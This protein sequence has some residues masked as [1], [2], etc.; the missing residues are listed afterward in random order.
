[1]RRR[2]HPTLRRGRVLAAAAALGGV[3]ALVAMLSLP[4]S[5]AAQ[6]T[7]ASPD[8]PAVHSAAVRALPGKRLPIRGRSVAIV[9]VARGVEATL[10][11]LHAEVTEREIRIDLSADVLFDFDKADLKP[12]ADADLGKVA[13]VARAN[14][15]TP[16]QVA[17]HTD[18]KG[19]DAYNQRLSERRAQSVKAWLVERGNVESAR[20]ETRGYGA[21]RPVAANETPGGA[22]DPEG[23]QRNR[24]VEITIRKE[25]AG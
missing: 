6:D 18:S 12:A 1:M 24:R 7:Y 19:A 4:C 9:G 11:A 25:G 23:R 13:E 3:P 17:G 14:P 20:I 21:T 10:E 22:D 15:G 8:L 2:F 5:A 16:I